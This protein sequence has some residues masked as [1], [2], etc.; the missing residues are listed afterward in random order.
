METTNHIRSGALFAL[1]A[2]VL[3]I[4]SAAAVLSSPGSDGD[5]DDLQV[6]IMA[7]NGDN[8]RNKDPYGKVLDQNDA[9]ITTQNYIQANT[10]YMRGTV[11][12]PSDAYV[13]SDGD[14]LHICVPGNNGFEDVMVLSATVEP[15][16]NNP[17][18]TRLF[19]GWYY[20]GDKH[21]F[22]A[23]VRIPDSGDAGFSDSES[24]LPVTYTFEGEE[25]HV[26]DIYARF[27][28]MTEGFGFVYNADTKTLT[29]DG[30][31]G[32]VMPDY[33]RVAVSAPWYAYKNECERIA[34]T[35]NIKYV[36]DYNFYAWPALQEVV[37]QATEENGVEKIGYG[38]F[39]NCTELKKVVSSYGRSTVEDTFPDTLKVMRNSAF[40]NTGLVNI[41]LPDSLYRLGVYTFMQC[42]SLASV[43]FGSAIHYVGTSCFDGCTSLT[44]IEM[45]SVFFIGTN[46]F[47][48]CTSL[49]SVDLHSQ[50][51]IS[52]EAFDGCTALASV[53]IPGGSVVSDTSFGDIQ[54]LD[55]GGTALAPADVPG[56]VYDIRTQ[57]DNGATASLKAGNEV[58]H[59]SVD[60]ASKRAERGGV[61]ISGG[62][63]REFA[64]GTSYTVS[65]P[66]ITIGGLTVTATP[67]DSNYTFLRWEAHSKVLAGSKYN[68]THVVATSKTDL[69]D[70]QHALDNHTTFVAVFQSSWTYT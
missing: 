11:A 63:G 48:G 40:R 54:F 25:A 55:A 67:A 23:Q 35:S 29:F 33:Y 13:Y 57:D 20:V 46:T 61:S 30:P 6:G 39:Y 24:P 60:A 36:G 38:A 3:M 42:R 8:D 37:F 44:T 43:T 12:I 62:D 65:G 64:A 19:A 7:G 21:G 53:T 5:G 1:L 28:V 69:A 14:D 50:T 9:N 32:T 15:D 17:D 56:S 45:P 2:A 47:R 16:A 52:P 59:F 31:A 70:G 49:E 10:H 27:T 58:I 4:A 18:L 51:F 66:T 68:S 34:F 22:V 26:V 41:D